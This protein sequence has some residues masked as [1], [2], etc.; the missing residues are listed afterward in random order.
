M[1]RLRQEYRNQPVAIIGGGAAD[2]TERA[3]A[4]GV[5]KILAENGVAIICGGGGGVMEAACMGAAEAGGVSIAVLPGLDPKA[6]S[7]HA[8]IVLPTDLGNLA[9]AAAAGRPDFSRNRV[10]TSAAVCAVAIGG[11]SGTANE[12][13]LTLQFGKPVFAICDAPDPEQPNDLTDKVKK[14]LFQRPSSAKAAAEAVLAFLR[15][16][17]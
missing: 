8:T 4:Y 17:K 15:I 6:A 16:D 14:R 5:A 13:K 7:P 10:I 1:H 12:I 11:K 3:N 9:I 2:E